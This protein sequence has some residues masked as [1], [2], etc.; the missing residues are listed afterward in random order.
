MLLSIEGRNNIVFVVFVAAIG[1]CLRFIDSS[2]SPYVTQSSKSFLFIWNL[3]WFS[4]SRISQHFV[5]WFDKNGNKQP[6]GMNVEQDFDKWW[7]QLWCCINNL[8]L[9]RK[10]RRFLVNQNKKDRLCYPLCPHSPTFFKTMVS[11]DWIIEIKKTGCNRFE[12]CTSSIFRTEN[13]C[14]H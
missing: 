1:V 8:Q 5:L 9:S 11:F 7:I 14:A 6:V 12:P 4:Y 13:R 10:N 2:W 3:I